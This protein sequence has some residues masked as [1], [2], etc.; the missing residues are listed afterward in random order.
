MALFFRHVPIRALAVVLVAAGS[1]CT[2]V[3]VTPQ[4]AEPP[5]Q[6]YHTVIVGS[7]EPKSP[8]LGYLNSY[9]HEG[10]VRR[11]TE[12]KAF[13]AIMETP[14][15][16]RSPDTLLVLGTVTEADKGDAVA[17]LLIGFGAGRQH[18]TA[19]L[20][21]KSSDGATLGHL[22]IRKAYSGGVGLGGGSFIDM[23]D[24]TKQV[25]EQA[26]QTLFDW[27]QGKQVGEYSG[28]K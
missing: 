9:F 26:A 24:L 27:S 7:L 12:L 2:T 20:E 11:L 17:R 18:V 5:K 6:T 25:G 19:E 23:E 28:S 13:D 4:S 14:A 8:D 15:T 22:E 21:L 10:L 1:A 16:A 3:T